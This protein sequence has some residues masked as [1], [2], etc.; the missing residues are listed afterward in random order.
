MLV[1]RARRGLLK[2]LGG[3]AALASTGVSGSAIG[4]SLLGT[5]VNLSHGFP[6]GIVSPAENP[7]PSEYFMDK[8]HTHVRSSNM[9][10]VRDIVA[11]LESHADHDKIVMMYTKITLYKWVNHSLEVPEWWF[12]TRLNGQYKVKRL[13]LE[14]C[15]QGMLSTKRVLSGDTLPNFASHLLKD[16]PPQWVY[17]WL[18]NSF[19]PSASS[20]SI[21]PGR[22]QEKYAHT[23]R[24]KPRSRK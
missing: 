15:A 8:I 20:D 24:H 7:V 3:G 12:N 13:A 10:S 18:D 4:G 22:R 21:E 9:D 2:M 17:D 14:Y 23:Y 11:W 19:T 5:G 6:E 16:S 1:D